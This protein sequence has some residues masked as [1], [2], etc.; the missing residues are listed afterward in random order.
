MGG[1]L[2]GGLAAAIV[3]GAA[4][5]WYQRLQQVRIPHNRWLFQAAFGLGAL[6]GLLA[7]LRGTGTLG[8]FAA[9]AALVGGG[10]FLGL[11]AISGQERR[12]PA[13]EVG[14]PVLDFEAPHAAG[15]SFDLASLR[16]RPFLLKFFRGHW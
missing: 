5:A 15:G 14:S 16:G 2:V 1:D 12:Q 8:G 9:V 7:L 13:V 4:I 11:R 6:L 3:L 10:V